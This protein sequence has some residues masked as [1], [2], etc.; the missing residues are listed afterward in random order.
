MIVFAKRPGLVRTHC[1]HCG[2]KALSRLFFMGEPV[3]NRLV[4]G[5]CF[6]TTDKDG[7]PLFLGKL[8]R[9]VH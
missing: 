6:G 4:C 5:Q 2:C 7:R 8:K 9:V 1:P 3:R